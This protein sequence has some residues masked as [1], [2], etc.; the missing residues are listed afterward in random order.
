LILLAELLKPFFLCLK[1]FLL[2]IWYARNFFQCLL[3]LISICLLAVSSH[4][5]FYHDSG[6][7]ASDT[8]VFTVN[9]RVQDF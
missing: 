2:F 9:H 8:E 1:T 5:S 7:D 4:L 6:E 3:L